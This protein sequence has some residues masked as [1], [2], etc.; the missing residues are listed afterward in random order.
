MTEVN[1]KLNLTVRR[2]AGATAARVSLTTDRL[3]PG[4]L[5]AD[6]I[7][8]VCFYIASSPQP[9]DARQRLVTAAVAAET[10]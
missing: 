6:C 3:A 10:A 2:L 5:K 8:Q 9:V 7:D 1:P 4:G